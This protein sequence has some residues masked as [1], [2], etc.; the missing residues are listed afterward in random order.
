MTDSP[1][2]DYP[3]Y[4][5]NPSTMATPVNLS[6]ALTGTLSFWAKWEIENAWDCCRLEISTD[7]GSSWTALA[8]QYTDDAS[9]QGVQVPA[10]EPVFD[11][12]QVVWVQNSVDLTP[13]LGVSDVRFRFRLS[14]DSSTHRDGFYFDDF[15]I[16]ITRQVTAVVGP[17]PDLL[18]RAFSAYPNPFNPQTTLRFE[19]TRGG[20]V[21]LTIYDLQGRL[22]RRILQASLPVGRHEAIWDGRDQRGA[23]APSGIYFGRVEVG[24]SAARTV[25]VMLVK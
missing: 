23:A 8:T 5:D 18:V 25:K 20:L 6:N 11:G 24:E 22:V 2:G 9:G 15:T 19:L 21:E 13:W 7:G 14:S 1:A 12:S 17:T 16:Q 10:G 3:N 4:A